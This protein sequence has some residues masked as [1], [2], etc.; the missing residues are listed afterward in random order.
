M[1]E[2]AGVTRV[3]FEE[4]ASDLRL[5]ARGR[6]DLRA[7][8]AHERPPLRLPVIDRADPVDRRLQAHEARRVREGGPP[9][10]GACLRC[11]PLVAFALRIPGLREGRVHF[12]ASGGAVE[13]RLVVQ[14]RGRAE[15]LLE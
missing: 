12:V 15:D 5:L 3:L 2:G 10:P 14:L 13:L 4:G 11:E 9:L 8:Q 1:T 7:V 6:V